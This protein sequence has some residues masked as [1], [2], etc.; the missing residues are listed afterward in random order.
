M[1]RDAR[2]D[3]A[4]LFTPGPIE[5]RKRLVERV[6]YAILLLTTAA[7]I[8]PLLAILAYLVVKAWPVLSWSF[9][10]RS[11]RPLVSLR[12]S[13]SMNMPEKSG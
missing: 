11:R 4:R 9:L 12:V 10:S 8:L 3:K 1:S 5:R 2:P 7:L 13:T 6:A